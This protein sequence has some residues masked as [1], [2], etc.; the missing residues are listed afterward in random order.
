[1]S[2]INQIRWYLFFK[3]TSMFL[4]RMVQT[5]LTHSSHC[6]FM[7]GMI[8][9][10]VTTRNC[11]VR[12]CLIQNTAHLN[13]KTAHIPIVTRS[14]KRRYFVL[15]I[16]HRFKSFVSKWNAEEKLTFHGKEVGYDV[17]ECVY[18]TL[19]YERTTEGQSHIY[20]IRDRRKVFNIISLS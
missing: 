12:S 8:V 17:V 11:S 20:E 16:R 2:I 7:L 9:N 18:L 13:A 1:M 4:V 6:S 10:S 19:F 14:Y 3:E 15:R 5:A